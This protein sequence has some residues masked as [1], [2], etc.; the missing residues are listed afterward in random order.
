MGRNDIFLSEMRAKV[1][2]LLGSFRAVKYDGN[3]ECEKAY[4]ENEENGEDDDSGKEKE[5]GGA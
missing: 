3:G 5:G 1:C 4:G 2:V